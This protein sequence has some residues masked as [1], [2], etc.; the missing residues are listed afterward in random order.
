MQTRTLIASTLVVPL[1][2]VLFLV[3]L[4]LSPTLV[5]AEIARAPDGRPD[6]SGRWANTARLSPVALKIHSGDSATLN[7]IDQRARFAPPKE[8]PGVLEW[9]AEPSYKPEH[10]DKVDHLYTKANRL[11]PVVSCGKPGLPRIGP[12]RRI[13]QLADEILFFYEDMSGDVYRIIPT[14]GRAHDEFANPSPYGDSIAAWEGVVLVVDVRSFDEGTWL[15]ERGYFHTEAMRVTERLMRDGENLVYQATVH[16]PNVLTGPWTMP[17]RV[18]TP[19]GLS[20]QESAPCI[21]G[22]EKFF[23][24]DDHHIQR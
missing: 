19:D 9:T 14:D 23:L 21:G 17:P 2:V 24:N 4:V 11:D 7:Q 20:L 6:L 13:V 12:P 3:I 16:E 18:V 8:L 10:Q 15:G 1:P 5:V 22:D